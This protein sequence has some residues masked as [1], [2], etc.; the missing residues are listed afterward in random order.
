MPSLK[1]DIPL[2]SNAPLY[3]VETEA[4]LILSERF[5]PKTVRAT[6]L[7][8]AFIAR[9]Q[10]DLGATIDIKD[11]ISGGHS[12]TGDFCGTDYIHHSTVGCFLGENFSKVASY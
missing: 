9:V 2:I 8:H 7:P 1:I 12:D 5:S 6:R 4:A 11:N 3:P 10:S